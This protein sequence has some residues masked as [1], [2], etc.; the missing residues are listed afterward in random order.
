MRLKLSKEETAS[1][2]IASKKRGFTITQSFTALLSLANAEVT[3]RIAGN[4]G[5]SRFEEV[6][7]GFKA[8][9]HYPTLLNFISHVR[10]YAL[11]KVRKSV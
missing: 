7:S 5:K 11:S 9:T 4:L 1:L 2:H 8:A 10:V 3:I 6:T